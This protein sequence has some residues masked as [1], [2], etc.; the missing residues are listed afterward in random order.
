MAVDLLATTLN[1]LETSARQTPYVRRSLDII[2]LRLESRNSASGSAPHSGNMPIV[3][4][5]KPRDDALATPDGS[6]LGNSILG[7][8]DMGMNFRMELVDWVNMN[9]SGDFVP[10]TESWAW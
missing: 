2:K 7:D 6:G 5:A 10:G 4:T 1:M 9:P 3:V 8:A